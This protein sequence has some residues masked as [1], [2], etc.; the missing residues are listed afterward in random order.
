MDQERHRGCEHQTDSG[1]SPEADRPG[2]PDRGTGMARA[3]IGCDGRADAREE[4]PDRGERR[5]PRDADMAQHD[6]QDEP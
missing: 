3:P 4:Q 2:A 5:Q 6:G 1:E